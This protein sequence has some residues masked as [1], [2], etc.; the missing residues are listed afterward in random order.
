MTEIFVV[1]DD[2]NI[3]QLVD[4][5]LVAAGFSVHSLVDGAAFQAALR[6]SFPDLILLDIMLPGTDGL[7]ILKRLKKSP[8]TSDIPVILLTAKSEEYDRIKGLDLG[9]DDYIS[10]PFSVMEMIA[11]V[12]AVLRRGVP[13]SNDGWLRVGALELHPGQRRVTAAGQPVTL[14]FREFELLEYLMRSAGLALSRDQILAEVWGYSYSGETRTV[15]MH[16]KALRAKLHD[17]G[18]LIV[19]VRHIGYK[20]EAS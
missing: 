6:E 9:A 20:I 2:D 18:G 5:A 1:E 17:L 11:R 12:R 3:R 4:Y 8:L 13:V 10:K 19:T 16:I 14:T 15:D 7:T